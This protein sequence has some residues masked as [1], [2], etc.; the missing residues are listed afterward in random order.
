[1]AAFGSGLPEAPTGASASHTNTSPMGPCEVRTFVR[2]LAKRRPSAEW[3][4]GGGCFAGC[5][6]GGGG[7]SWIDR[8]TRLMVG[9]RIS[10]RSVGARRTEPRVL[11]LGLPPPSSP[12]KKGPPGVP[13]GTRLHPLFF[14]F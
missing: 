6:S 9:Q 13:F 10:G 4:G 12:C 7:S 14:F 1:M 11:G 3:P 8:H 2:T 5:C